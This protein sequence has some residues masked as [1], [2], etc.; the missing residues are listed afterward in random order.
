MRN[1]ICI[2]DWMCWGPLVWQEF[3]IGKSG[4]AKEQ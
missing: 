2:D 1:V 4:K 3:E